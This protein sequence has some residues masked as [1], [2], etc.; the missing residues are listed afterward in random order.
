MPSSSPRQTPP[1]RMLFR[2][3]FVLFV[4]AAFWAYSAYFQAQRPASVL[5]PSDSQAPAERPIVDPSNSP[6]EKSLFVRKVVLRDARGRVLYRGDIDL[7]PTLERIA[8]DRR[9]RFSND[10]ST[11]QNREKRL[12]RQPAGYYREWVVPTPNEEG[13]GPQR[14]VTGKDGEVWYT[15]DH[16]RTFRRIPYTW[17]GS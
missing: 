7:S 14:I 1:Q 11:F 16:Y 8:A 15:G 6:P 4:M 5:P 10:G 9:L 13:P 3:G 12:P 2:L 17:P